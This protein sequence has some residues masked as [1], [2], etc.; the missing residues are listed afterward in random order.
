MTKTRIKYALT[1]KKHKIQKQTRKI[2]VK[3]KCN[4]HLK[5][6]PFKKVRFGGGPPSS[7]MNIFDKKGSIYTPDKTLSQSDITSTIN[8]SGSIDTLE[9]KTDTNSRGS[10]DELNDISKNLDKTS[11][12]DNNESVFINLPKPSNMDKNGHQVKSYFKTPEAYY[13]HVKNTD[14]Q[15]YD[16]Y[17]NDSSI[18]RGEELNGGGPNKKIKGVFRSNSSTNKNHKHILNNKKT[19]SDRLRLSNLNRPKSIVLFLNG[20]GSI[21]PIRKGSNQKRLNTH[22]CNVRMFNPIPITGMACYGEGGDYIKDKS[23][24]IEKTMDKYFTSLMSLY[25]FN[26]NGNHATKTRIDHYDT[27]RKFLDSEEP[28]PVY[29]QINVIRRMKIGERM[30]DTINSVIRGFFQRMRIYKSTNSN[31][32]RRYIKEIEHDNLSLNLLSALTDEKNTKLMQLNMRNIKFDKTYSFAVKETSGIV[33]RLNGINVLYYDDEFDSENMSAG[34]MSKELSIVKDPKNIFTKDAVYEKL[35]FRETSQEGSKI[36]LRTI[37]KRLHAYNFKNIYI[38]DLTCNVDSFNHSAPQSDQGSMVDDYSQEN[39]GIHNIII[40]PE[41]IASYIINVKELQEAGLLKI[42]DKEIKSGKKNLIGRIGFKWVHDKAEK[43]NVDGMLTSTDNYENDTSSS[44]EESENED[45]DDTDDY[46]ESESKDEPV[47]FFDNDNTE[48]TT[49]SDAITNAVVHS[50]IPNNSP[51]LSLYHN[52][53]SYIHKGKFIVSGTLRPEYAGTKL[54][55]E[56]FPTSAT[57][58]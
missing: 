52:L 4:N 47:N 58:L 45:K 35:F 31:K 21:S 30:S 41:Q 5:F 37:I 23:I 43:N 13:N 49:M 17:L 1:D 20:H 6:K 51:F 25:P 40:T 48:I 33:D 15:L 29:P 42:S 11:I 50:Q 36:S 2:K 14:Y 12:F 32:V 16:E 44:E 9:T 3:S 24:M 22:G 18:Y 46:L 54:D 28:L 34:K 53:T 56:S 38:Y 27:F 10:L 39:D 26:N 19:Q 55:P 7:I 8:S 57:E